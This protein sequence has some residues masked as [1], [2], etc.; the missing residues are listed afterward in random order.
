MKEYKIINGTSYDART[1][2]AVVTVLENA[3]QNRTRLH[4]SVGDPESGG[5]WLEEFDTHGYVG[6][7]MGPVKVPLLLATRRSSGGGAILDHCI[8]RV[9]E[10]ASGR[11]LYR[12]P[13]YDHGQLVIQRKAEPLELHDGRVLAVDAL[14]DGQRYASFETTEKARRWLQRLGVTAVIAT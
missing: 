3:R 7:S 12:H 14:R 2:T 4:I 10:T 5:D 13:H 1:P 8:V 6:R 9:R 11:V